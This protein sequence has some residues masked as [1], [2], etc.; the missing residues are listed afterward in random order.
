MTKEIAFQIIQDSFSSLYR[1]G[2]LEEDMVIEENTVILGA[3]SPLD[4]IAF[5]TFITDL[6]DRMSS[7]A[8]KEIYLILAE[9]HKFNA[10]HQ[11]LTAG[12][13]ADYLFHIAER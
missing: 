5:V 12:T 1:S 10:D 4:S 9:I 8:A 13:L 11:Y 6:E 3:K 7:E 2:M